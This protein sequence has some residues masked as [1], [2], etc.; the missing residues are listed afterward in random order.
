MTISESVQSIRTDITGIT[1]QQN[2]TTTKVAAREEGQTTLSEEIQSVS[3][4]VSQVEQNVYTKP[5][6]DGKVDTLTTDIETVSGTVTSMGADVK[7]LNKLN[8]HALLDSSY[9]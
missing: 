2:T 5:E 7:K 1:E 3:E 6:I 8:T 4:D 9:E